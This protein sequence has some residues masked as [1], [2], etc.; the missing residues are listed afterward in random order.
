MC[1]KGSKMITASCPVNDAFLLDDIRAMGCGTTHSNKDLVANSDLV[2]LAVKPAVMPHVCREIRDLVTED[3]I[4]VSMAAG[5]KLETL[6]KSL[7]Q[8]ARVRS[9]ETKIVILMRKQATFEVRKIGHTYT[10]LQLT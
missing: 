7:N 10:H 3:K 9:E 5:V 1:S 2:M 6:Q 8:K 4:M